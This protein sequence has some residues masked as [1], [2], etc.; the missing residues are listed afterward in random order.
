MKRQRSMLEFTPNNYKR[1]QEECS[2]CKE[3]IYPES[4]QQE[5]QSLKSSLTSTILTDNE[6]PKYNEEYPSDIAQSRTDSPIQPRL[7]SFPKTIINKKLRSFGSKWFCSKW[8]ST[9][10]WNIR[11]SVMQFIAFYVDCFLVNLDTEQTFVK[12]GFRNWKKANS[13]FEKHVQSESH[14]KSLELWTG[15][16]Q[17]ETYGNVAMY[18]DSQRATQ[19]ERQSKI[20]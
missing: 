13:C 4:S 20:P 2:Q 11:S 12:I 14:K 10:I 16:N 17:T 15:F 7:P 1:I 8:N 18:L 19:V 6:Q 9:N 5:I 3:P